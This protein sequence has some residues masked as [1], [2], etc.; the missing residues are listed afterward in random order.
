MKY[1]WWK[2]ALVLAALVA[3]FFA[4][5]PPAQKLKPG[6]DL[7]GGTTFIY[8]VRVPEDAD[9]EETI[10]GLINVLRDRVDP[11]GTRNLIWR[12]AAGNRIEI[13][14]ALASQEAKARRNTYL[15]ARQALLD[16]NLAPA[17]VDSALSLEGEARTAELKRLAGN[18]AELLAKLQA[19]AAA[20]DAFV[21]A[22]TPYQE[23]Q[24][25]FNEAQ[26]ALA[27]LP[28]DASEAQ[29][30]ELRDRVNAQQNDVIAKAE[31]YL[32][33][34]Q[35]LDAAESAVFTNNVD[36]VELEQVLGTPTTPTRKGRP[37]RAQVAK[38]LKDRHPARAAQIDQ[39]LTTYAS[40][41]EVKGPLDDPN[42]LIALLRGSGVLEFR[43]AATPNEPDT[44]VYREQLQERGPRAGADRPWRWFPVDDITQFIN[45][46]SDEEFLDADPAGFFARRGLV[47]AAYGDGY[48]VLLGNTPDRAM[49]REQAW[50]LTK[51]S[52]DR[53]QLGRRAVA[54]SLDAPGGD[55]MGAITGPNIGKPM[56]ILLDGQVI[57][58]PNLN[59]EIRGSGIITGDFSE[60]EMTYLLRTIKA[61]STEAELGEYPISIKTTGPQLGQDNLARGVEA[62][63][64]SLVIVAAFLIGYYF[65]PGFIAFIG[66]LCTTLFVLA[67]MAMFEAT[68]TLPGIAGVVLTIG[69]AVDA[70]VL[71]YER[72]REELERKADVATALRL[73]YQKA[74]AAIIDSNLTTFIT[75][76]VLFYTATADIKGFAITMMIGIFATMFSALF[77]CRV[78]LELY[79]LFFRP[80]TMSMLP[81]AVPA[82]RHML[83]PKVDWMSRRW[84]FFGVSVTLSVLGLLALAV[85]GSDMLDIEF[86]SGTS[87]SFT[88]A[89]EQRM[90]IED[91]RAR[92]SHFADA[93]QAAVAGR[94]PD[95][96]PAEARPYFADAQ[97][98]ARD[99][100]ARYETRAAE[101][102]ASGDPAPE[103][104]DFAALHDATI[105]TEGDTE[106]SS[107]NGFNVATLITDPQTVADAV[108]V[109]L[110][111]KLDVSRPI[112][113]TGVRESAAA[114]SALFPIT[115]QSL[116]ASINRPD[117]TVDLPEFVGGVAI[118]LRDLSP[119][120][121]VADVQ[122]R[123]NRMRQQPAYEGLGF[124][125]S[126]VIGLD[127]S[128]EDTGSGEPRFTSIAVV[129]SDHG[130]NYAEDASGLRE[131]GGLGET[132]WALVNDALTRDT[133]LA[134]VSSFSSQVSDQMKRDAIAA[135]TLSMLAI[136][137]YIWFRFG[138]LRYSVGAVLALV[139]DCAIALGLVA[140]AGWLYDTPIGAALLLDP[141][142]INLALIA[143]V[144]TIMGYSLNDTIV[145]FDRIRENRGRLSYA[146]PQIVNDAINQTLS[147][148]VLTGTTT[149]GAVLTLY[150]IGGPAIHGFAFAMFIGILVG[151]YSS[152]AV[153]APIVLLGA[154]PAP[155]P[156]ERSTSTVTPAPAA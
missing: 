97:R 31:A 99:A 150:L 131:P 74:M 28:T 2:P 85:R 5:W 116:G 50:E 91:V 105:V 129:T 115:S 35:A 130:T 6:L 148:T 117:I 107:A 121:T 95:A 53:D 3:S 144:L 151:T 52:P 33:A 49:T 70:N 127:R 77:V 87:V 26:A 64:I 8:D 72:M 134:S 141:F 94:T 40:Y 4:I 75:C 96:V 104:P 24:R 48:Y 63:M 125:P 83:E 88:L 32:T 57:S 142:K 56:A 80:R 47:G 19:V 79:V 102:A 18:D 136:L 132:E 16:T 90:P 67:A 37:D 92:L 133:S 65:L 45:D 123:V 30:T 23:A 98:V 153:A 103:A 21:A 101:A 89:G 146:T 73:G 68:F 1:P 39:V 81:L 62:A 137:A 135:I 51:A 106:G 76:V 20:H 145:V 11:T 41:E 124:R 140:V 29:R 60:Q 119:A 110:G 14:M 118:V 71:I 122:E 143:A 120:V 34:K 46:R 86:R 109:S 55:L 61:G 38:E 156:A 10:N 58:A 42:D 126:R 22:N 7:A 147:R 113:F 138:N 93:A 100:Q 112:S 12:Q 9:A 13:Q 27:A 17:T 44:A 43:I 111:D 128:P 69:M 59:D 25:A 155:A 66:V 154:K 114:T 139:H 15:E 84:L 54:F 36:P 108:K 149:L 152:I 82:V 78:L